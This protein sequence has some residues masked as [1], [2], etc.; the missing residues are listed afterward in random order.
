MNKPNIAVLLAAYNGVQWLP[1]QIDTIFKQEGVNLTLFISVDASSDGTEE[2]VSTLASERPDV[3]VLPHGLKFGGAAK[4]FFRLIRDV[5]FSNF[6]YVALADQDDVWLE[7]KLLRAH[8]LCSAQGYEAY[9]SSVMAFWPDGSQRLID[10]SQPKTRYD[11]LFEPAG[12]G[13]T[14]VLR[15]RN[16]LIFKEFLLDNWATVNEVTYHDWMLYAFFRARGYKWFI[17]SQYKMLY[18]QHASNQIGANSGWRA[19][20]SRASLLLS[21]W[22]REEVRKVT[23]LVGSKQDEF[24]QKILA[25]KNA[26]SRLYLLRHINSTRRKTKEKWAL[27]LMTVFWIF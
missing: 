27:F 8:A 21:G 22:Y 4:N 16:A 5:D 10:K 9:S 24:V 25:E 1:E 3:V 23:N 15:V 12:P 19:V 2:W 17:D 18:R 13:C 6:D 7:D 26:G 14:Y 11:Y 20:T